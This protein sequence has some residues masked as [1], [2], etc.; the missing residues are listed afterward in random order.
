MVCD[1][2]YLLHH[3]GVFSEITISSTETGGLLFLSFSFIIFFFYSNQN[4]PFLELSLILLTAQ[5]IFI[6]ASPLFQKPYVYK[7]R[8]NHIG[9]ERTEDIIA[10]LLYITYQADLLLSNYIAQLIQSGSSSF[11]HGD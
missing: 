5:A 11:F 3:D 2:V 4:G 10:G 9:G 1:F 6:W 7:K 8:P